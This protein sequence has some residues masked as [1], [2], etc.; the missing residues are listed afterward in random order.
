MCL[1]S[2]LLNVNNSSQFPS[3]CSFCFIHRFKLKIKK[4]TIMEIAHYT[5]NRSIIKYLLEK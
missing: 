4:L 5:L 3:I 1:Y 2:I